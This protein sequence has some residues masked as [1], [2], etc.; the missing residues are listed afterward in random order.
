MNNAT[1]FAQDT[2]SLNPPIS[3]SQFLAQAKQHRDKTTCI[4]DGRLID[5]FGR[6]ITDKRPCSMKGEP[7]TF[8]PYLY[9]VTDIVKDVQSK[10]ETSEDWCSPAEVLDS[11]SF[12][13]TEALEHLISDF[14]YQNHPE[15]NPARTARILAETLLTI[16]DFFGQN[17]PR[18]YGSYNSQGG[19]HE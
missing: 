19:C 11:M 8:A 14:D 3:L 2:S 7:L 12:K 17:Q 1:F 9:T 15:S 10:R 4:V 6:D 16:N 5:E 13:L 18:S